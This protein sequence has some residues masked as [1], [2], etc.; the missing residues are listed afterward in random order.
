MLIL[1]SDFWKQMQKANRLVGLVI[2]LY[3]SKS[4][5]ISEGKLLLLNSICIF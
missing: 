3:E 1:I 5:D 4:I 2:V